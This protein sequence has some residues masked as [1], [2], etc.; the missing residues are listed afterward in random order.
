M[1]YA[2]HRT[3]TNRIVRQYVN[4][5]QSTSNRFPPF[6]S[7][8]QGEKLV[9]D[10][11]PSGLN[12]LWYFVF[13][14]ITLPLFL[15]GLVIILYAIVV[16]KTTHYVITDKR[17]VVKTGW[18]NV[19]LTEVRIADIRGVNLLIGLWQRIIGTG[20][21]TIGTAATSDAE[22]VMM[23]VANPKIVV[24]KINSQRNT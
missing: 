2:D 20:N 15:A 12:F 9:L 7:P 17:V 6:F 22:I 8:M 4:Q 19:N 1:G 21:I 24:E 11:R 5:G 13:G 16:I 10:A 23:G 18:F 3:Q 14:V